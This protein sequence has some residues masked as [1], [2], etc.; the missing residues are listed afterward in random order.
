MADFL[1]CLQHLRLEDVPK[2][3]PN[4][5]FQWFNMNSTSFTWKTREVKETQM[6]KKKAWLEQEREES[7]LC[8]YQLFWN[9]WMWTYR[10]FFFRVHLYLNHKLKLVYELPLPPWVPYQHRRLWLKER[11]YICPNRRKRKHLFTSDA[12][13]LAHKFWIFC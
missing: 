3:P 11:I 13:L 8:S 7:R 12:V 2:C 4:H 1:V 5:F 9:F 10:K 6:K